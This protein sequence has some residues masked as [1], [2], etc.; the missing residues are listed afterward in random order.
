MTYEQ[1]LLA[2][3]AKMET[4]RAELDQKIAVLRGMLTGRTPS[5]RATGR[6]RSD[7]A[8][9]I[10]AAMRDGETH[11]AQ[12]LCEHVPISRNAMSAALFRMKKSGLV[13]SVGYGKFR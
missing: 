8:E 3:I 11:T 2:A 4:E 1:D 5:S 9:Q 7:T 10:L 6:R 13:V 12:D